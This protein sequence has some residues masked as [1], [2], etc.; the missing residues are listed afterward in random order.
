LGQI[1]SDEEHLTELLAALDN[2][3]IEQRVPLKK[4]GTNLL[5]LALSEPPPEVG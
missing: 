2:E 5:K 4:R 3:M 1:A